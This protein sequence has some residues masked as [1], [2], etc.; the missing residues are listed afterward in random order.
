MFSSLCHSCLIKIAVIKS[1][2][3]QN[4]PKNKVKSK[5]ME[6]T[7]F[8]SKGSSFCDVT[9]NDIGIIKGIVCFEIM[10]VKCDKNIFENKNTGVSK[11]YI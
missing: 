8:F 5:S 9:K 3:N 2:P 1:G 4:S 11:S 6:H 10:K 7:V